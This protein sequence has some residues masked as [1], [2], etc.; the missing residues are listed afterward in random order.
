MA[1]SEPRDED[2]Q[3]LPARVAAAEARAA[4][5][6]AWF[7][8]MLE[9]SPT[10]MGIISALEGRYVRANQPLA[11]LFGMTIDELLA[12]DPYA[13][14]QRITHPDEMVAE[15]NLFAQVAVGARSFYRLEKRIM[16]PDGTTRWGLLTF[17]GIHDDPV[18][19]ATPVKAL[20]YSV[21]HIVDIT[22]QKAMAETLQRREGELRHAQKIDGIGRLAAGIAH[23][24]NNL[25]TVIMGHGEM[26]KALAQEG[27]PSAPEL[28][29]GLDAILAASERAASL[30]AQ[31]LAHGRR[32]TVAP[33]TFVLSE[34]VGKLQKLLGRT[35]GS[36]IHV[37]QSLTAEGA[38]FADQ[39]QVGQVVMNLMLNARDAIPEGGRIALTTRDVVVAPGAGRLGPPGP[40]AWVVLAISDDGHGMDPE[41]RARIFEPFFT[42]RTDRP[43]TEGTG[44]GLATVQRIV[45]EIGGFIDVASAPG[46]GT[47]V[48]IFFPRVANTPPKVPAPEAPRPPEPAPNSR[49]VLVIEDEPSVRSLVANVLLGAHYRVVVAR[50]GEEG[51]RLLESERE[52]FHLIVTDLM[53]PSIGGMSLARRLHE[54]GNGPRMLFI[55]GYSRHTPTELVTFGRLLPK[56]FTPAQLLDAVRGAIEEP[57]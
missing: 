15:Q 19:P 26:L 37:D 51:L 55:S 52:P 1:G 24:F 8:V 13:L 22:D 5:L 10:A 38:I 16:R 40:G 53:M 36:D 7:A 20:L 39:G 27:T 43:G 50:D 28:K 12:S 54:R 21:V 29:E 25:L 57:R 46:Q 34:A 56:P 3:T 41:V 4:H 35:I 18:D 14:A 11:D 30:T 49:R 17:G 42:T 48:T 32:E 2:G 47:R 31:V 23:D 9:T 33:R 44:L 6:Q 45:T